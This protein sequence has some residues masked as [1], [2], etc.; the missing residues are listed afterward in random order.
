MTFEEAAARFRRFPRL[1]RFAAGGEPLI[2]KD[3]A[4]QT[5]LTA[6]AGDF[7][8]LALRVEGRYMGRLLPRD[9]PRE[10]GSLDLLFLD[11]RLAYVHVRDWRSP[12]WKNV[13]EF[14]SWV[15]GRYGLK[16]YGWR[17]HRPKVELPPGA[18]HDFA[19]DNHVIDC[20]GF[21]VEASCIGPPG[22]GDVC[23]L[24]VKDPGAPEIVAGR[25]LAAEDK[26]P[27]R[28]QRPRRP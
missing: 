3:A 14:K 27:R 6:H 18:Y 17:V 8:V 23:D 26:G 2:L 5:A 10:F 11:R 25:R 13:D 4:G 22:P 9:V 24:T 7:G 28:P 20:D 16:G 1:A 15:A 19:T 12:E 21:V